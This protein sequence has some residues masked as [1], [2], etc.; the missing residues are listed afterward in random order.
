MTTRHQLTAILHR[1]DQTL[2]E[3][4]EVRRMPMG[5]RTRRRLK[6]TQA[7]LRRAKFDAERMLRGV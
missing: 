3:A 5:W 1:I 4:E 7:M 6:R 2:A